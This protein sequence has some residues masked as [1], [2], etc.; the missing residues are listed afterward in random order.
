[1]TAHEAINA[2]VSSGWTA[3]FYSVGNG[4]ATHPTKRLRIAF[5]NEHATFAWY[6][7]A[8]GAR[9]TLRCPMSEYLIHLENRI[10]HAAPIEVEGSKP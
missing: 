5:Q 1:M 10:D 3:T 9:Q 4:V 7:V 2:L 8:G 6:D